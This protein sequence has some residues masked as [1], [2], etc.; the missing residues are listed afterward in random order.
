MIEASAKDRRRFAGVFSGAEDDNDVGRTS[1]IESG[2]PRD[3]VVIDADVN[4]HQCEEPGGDEFLVCV[5]KQRHQ[6]STS[7]MSSAEM[8]PSRIMRQP[9]A[10][11][12]RS[13]MVEATTR[14]VVPPS[15]MSGMRSPN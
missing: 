9:F 8:A 6:P 13:T 3:A 2:L 14:G 7:M 5:A 10:S 1:L 11:S 12:V 15:T 4:Q